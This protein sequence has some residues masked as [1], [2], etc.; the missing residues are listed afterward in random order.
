MERESLIKVL[1]RQKGKKKDR[2]GRDN[3]D[4]EKEKGIRENGK[5]VN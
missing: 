3:D 2:R 5:I 4:I 1:D